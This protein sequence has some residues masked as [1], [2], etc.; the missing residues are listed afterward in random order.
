MS[1]DIEGAFWTEES[2]H[3]VG[4]LSV[5]WIRAHRLTDHITIFFILTRYFIGKM[6]KTHIS[7]FSEGRA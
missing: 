1:D 7:L 2:F 3:R 5:R 4:P 6:I